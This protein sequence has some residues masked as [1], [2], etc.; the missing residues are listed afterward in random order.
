[1]RCEGGKIYGAW[2]SN[3]FQD[4]MQEKLGMKV[5]VVSAIN[6]SSE[7]FQRITG[8]HVLLYEEGTTLTEP[9]FI[10]E[11]QRGSSYLNK[12]QRDAIILKRVLKYCKDV[13]DTIEHFGDDYKV[14]EESSVYRGSASMG[15]FQIGEHTNRLSDDFR[16]KFTDM[17]W[18]KIKSMRNIIAHEYYDID[19]VKLWEIMH[20]YVPE[21]QKYCQ[22]ALK[23]MQQE[24]E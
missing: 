11:E 10:L 21:L 23:Q 8:D 2:M 24:G 22:Q 15:V 6:P 7:F 20:E 9:V 4:D 18:P 14:F 3:N 16:A 1:L 19:I 13:Y 5:D 17:P 12:S